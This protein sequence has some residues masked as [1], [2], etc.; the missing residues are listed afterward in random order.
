MSTR[1]GKPARGRKKRRKGGRPGGGRDEMAQGTLQ[2]EIDGTDE[3]GQGTSPGAT[4]GTG[5]HCSLP[6]G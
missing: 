1:K 4:G 2:W 5:V 3:I 6:G